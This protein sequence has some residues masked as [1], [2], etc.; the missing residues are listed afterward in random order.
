MFGDT[1]ELVGCHTFVVL[2]FLFGELFFE[3]LEDFYLFGEEGLVGVNGEGEGRKGGL[4]GKL[5]VFKF[6]VGGVGDQASVVDK[7]HADGAGVE[8]VTCAVFWVLD[9]VNNPLL[10]VVDGWFLLVERGNLLCLLLLILF[11]H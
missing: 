6:E 8:G 4:F 3:V 1:D 10:D 7:H 11:T 5:D 2:L 9:E